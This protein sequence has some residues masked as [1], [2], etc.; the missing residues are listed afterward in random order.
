MMVMDLT[1][2]V[3][4]LYF[5]AGDSLLNLISSNFLVFDFIIIYSDYDL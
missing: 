4:K 2:P 5:S 3:D 1:L